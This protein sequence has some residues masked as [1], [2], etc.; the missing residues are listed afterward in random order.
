MEGYSA[1]TA[2]VAEVHCVP[3]TTVT[4]RWGLYGLDTVVPAVWAPVNLPSRTTFDAISV[5]SKHD[6]RRRSRS[7]LFAERPV[8]IAYLTHIRRVLLQWPSSDVLSSFP[9]C[10]RLALSSRRLRHVSGRPAEL[11]VFAVFTGSYHMRP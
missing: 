6:V 1:D 7:V 8:A 5:A 3:T 11:D 10:H 9:E 4:P 2:R